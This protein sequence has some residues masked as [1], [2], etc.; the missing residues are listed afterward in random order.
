MAVALLVKN[1]EEII[2]I[3]KSLIVLGLDNKP[4]PIKVLYWNCKSIG[5]PNEDLRYFSHW[6]LPDF[7]YLSEP[8]EYNPIKRSS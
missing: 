2:P 4:F 7:L 3:D 6:V 5:N 8:W 1:Q